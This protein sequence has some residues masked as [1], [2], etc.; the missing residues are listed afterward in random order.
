MS[1]RKSFFLAPFLLMTLWTSSVAAYR[2]GL[3]IVATG[4]YIELAKPL[5]ESA[6][7]HFLRRHQVTFFLFTDQ[8]VEEKADVVVLPHRRCGWPYDTLYRYY[9]YSDHREILSNM[10][11]LFAMDADMLFVKPVGDEILE[12]L[13]AVRFPESIKY[14]ESYEKHIESAAYIGPTEGDV[15]FAGA[16]YGGKTSNFFEMMTTVTG[17]VERDAQ[18]NI[19]PIWHDESYNNRY[20][21]DH[22]PTLV[23]SP[24]YCYHEWWA[25]PYPRKILALEKN[26]TAMRK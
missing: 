15:Y 19:M 21:I 13:V 11:Y 14:R 20:F 10:D 23:L 4:R 1:Y 17:M 5:I 9:A 22:K 25:V 18:H 6:R 7:R 8:V 2:V 26:Y 3:L 12:D 24:S 16:F